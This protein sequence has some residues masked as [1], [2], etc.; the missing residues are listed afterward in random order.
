MAHDMPVY[1]LW[2]LNW[3]VRL[4]IGIKRNG[5][6][7]LLLV[8]F[9]LLSLLLSSSFISLFRLLFYIRP[10]RLSTAFALNLDI[11]TPTI[12]ISIQI[13]RLLIKDRSLSQPTGKEINK[14]LYNNIQRT[15]IVALFLA[16]AT[17]CTL[18]CFY[19]VG[20]SVE[21]E[22]VLSR[23]WPD[24]RPTPPCPDSSFELLQ[25]ILSSPSSILTLLYP[26]PPLSSSSFTFHHPSL[27]LYYIY[28]TQLDGLVGIVA[29]AFSTTTTAAY[30]FFH[31]SPLFNPFI[32]LSH[33][34][35]QSPYFSPLIILFVYCHLPYLVS[36]I[37]LYVAFSDWQPWCVEEASLATGISSGRT[38]TVWAPRQ[39]NLGAN[40]PQILV[41]HFRFFSIFFFALRMR[42]RS[43]LWYVA[44]WLCWCVLY[45]ALKSIY[46]CSFHWCVIRCSGSLSYDLIYLA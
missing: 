36:F 41:F 18:R 37:S 26:H 11:Y 40:N 14:D 6:K 29:C 15:D 28:C 43:W 25:D 23:S 10:L 42:S 2:L 16:T 46:L 34:P 3:I 5:K 31:F 7:Y 19:I 33:I 9:L 38:C 27:W 30:L 8:Y 32:T 24:H 39:P 1:V 13:N 22:I 12:S 20:V 4:A 21:K 35:L 17:S 44:V 45:R